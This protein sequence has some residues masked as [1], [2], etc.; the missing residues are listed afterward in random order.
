[1]IDP[2]LNGT[3]FDFALEEPSLPPAPAP[4]PRK[5]KR[6]PKKEKDLSEVLE[7]AIREVLKNKDTKPADRLK[8]IE[9]GAKLLAI[10]HKIEGGG[11]AGNF[12]TKQ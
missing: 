10:R 6:E 7:A 3:P 11:D 2:P 9:A 5:P 12:F 8:A 4:A 1:M